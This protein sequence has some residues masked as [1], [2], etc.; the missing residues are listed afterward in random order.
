MLAK[1]EKEE[2]E[3][4]GFAPSRQPQAAWRLSKKFLGEIFG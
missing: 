2:Q 4:A 3:Q 1:K